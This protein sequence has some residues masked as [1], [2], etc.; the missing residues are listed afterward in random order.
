MYIYRISNRNNPQIN[1]IGQ[2]SGDFPDTYVNIIPENLNTIGGARIIEHIQNAYPTWKKQK[3]IKIKF[4]EKDEI[5]KIKDAVYPYG[6]VDILRMGRLCESKLELLSIEDFFQQKTVEIGKFLDCW[7]TG[8]K[9]TN[10]PDELLDIAEMMFIAYEKGEGRD[11]TKAKAAAMKNAQNTNAIS[12]GR[13]YSCYTTGKILADEL[14]KRV[15]A[16]LSTIKETGDD[17]KIK[18]LLDELSTITVHYHPFD[19]R[20]KDTVAKIWD[21]QYEI[22]AKW[23]AKKTE[24]N[25]VLDFSKI[26]GISSIISRVIRDSIA[27]KI[28][29]G[30]ND[31]KELKKH[32]KLVT[33]KDFANDPQL[34]KMTTDF[35]IGNLNKKINIIN[36]AFGGLFSID[37][38]M[39]D[40]KISSTIRQE[41]ARTI[42]KNQALQNLISTITNSLSDYINGISKQK[43]NNTIKNT[44][45]NTVIKIE[46]RRPFYKAMK[47]TFGGREAKQIEE[48]LPWGK[49]SQ[50][51]EFVKGLNWEDGTLFFKKVACFFFSEMMFSNFTSKG[52][53][54]PRYSKKSTMGSEEFREKKATFARNMR[55]DLFRMYSSNI[56]S[57]KDVLYNQMT[58]VVLAQRPQNNMEG[59]V[60]EKPRS[61]F[62]YCHRVFYSFKFS[63]WTLTEY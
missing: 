8:E 16:S 55:N 26:K 6:A 24:Q 9:S 58:N 22:V 52:K 5:E 18:E 38:D 37:V 59:V 21:P 51:E 53:E 45:K 62:V 43:I 63:P 19:Y 61:A 40:T 57:V 42:L 50:P 41:I 15:D 49:I 46:L 36:K 30:P 20:V 35:V 31:K 10:T 60:N 17:L 32:S 54:R 1:Y 27:H 7:Y 3:D 39:S 14:K 44:L 4:K 11:P 25:F 33:L 48:S 12:G 13:T 23:I 56:G 2:A 29:T 34:I 28:K 47:V